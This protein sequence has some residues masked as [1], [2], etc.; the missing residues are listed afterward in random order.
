MCFSCDL[1]LQSPIWKSF[2]NLKNPA[3][4]NLF[5]TPLCDTMEEESLLETPG[6]YS[7]YGER[8][9]GGGGSSYIHG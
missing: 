4:Q 5:R 7:V 1:Y 9:M 8:N 6:L 2:L 3:K